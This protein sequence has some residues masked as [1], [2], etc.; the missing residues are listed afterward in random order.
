MAQM[1]A[2]G[3]VVQATPQPDI[4]TLMLIIAIVAL[5]T[6]IA[7][8]LYNLMSAVPTGYGLS[9]GELFQPPSELID[10]R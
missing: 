1:P 4:Y 9:V 3:P 5:I 8:V 7:M 6:T 2:K 10:A